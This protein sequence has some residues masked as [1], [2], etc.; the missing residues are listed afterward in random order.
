M[1]GKLLRA[2]EIGRQH[3]AKMLEG[4]VYIMNAVPFWNGIQSVKKLRFFD[5]KRKRTAVA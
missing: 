3:D 5:A 4:D 1:S 2:H